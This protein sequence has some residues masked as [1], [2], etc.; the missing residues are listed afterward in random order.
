[1]V[2]FPIALWVF[3]FVCDLLALNSTNNSWFWTDLAFYTMAGG[4]IGALGAAV[5]GF[6]DY[7]GLPHSRV[8]HIATIHMVLNVT[9]LVLY[10]FN[11][12][13]R[14]H[15]AVKATSSGVAISAIALVLL[16]IS[17]WLGGS[18]VH[19]HGVAVERTADFGED[20]KDRAA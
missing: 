17:G 20:R 8:R 11:L 15:D 9:V 5:P 2:M 10:I 12:G 16:A 6:I 3:S 19:V 13:L 1:L 7:V 4:I 14:V 18:L